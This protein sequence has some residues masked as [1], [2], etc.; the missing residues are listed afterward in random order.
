MN[1]K[2]IRREV[3][4]QIAGMVIAVL[5]VIA[6]A[7]LWRTPQTWGQW[8]V[9]ATYSILILLMFVSA[10][11]IFRRIVRRDYKQNGR[12]TPMPLFLQLLIWGLFFAF[13][14]IYNPIDWAWSQSKISH[15]ISI[16]GI[17]G[18]ACVWMGLA[19]VIG[20][21]FWLGMSRSFGQ[22]G[23]KLETSGPYRVTRN[24]QLMAG[25]FLIIGCVLLWP[26]WYALGWLALFA[27]MAHMMVLA[28][29][30]HLHNLYGEEYKQYCMRVS[31]YFGLSRKL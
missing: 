5:A 7:Y 26:S 13:P 3:F 10:W 20:A 19:F 14:C 17:I 25:A 24:P 9:L 11:I 21:M 23:E 4:G 2:I 27:A 28:E 8:A 15:A 30:E 6:A 12:L 31:R 16:L 29:E 1:R 22:K 18:W